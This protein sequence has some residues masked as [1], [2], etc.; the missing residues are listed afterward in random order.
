MVTHPNGAITVVNYIDIS[1]TRYLGVPDALELEDG[2][3]VLDEDLGL[4]VGG[5]RVE[6]VRLEDGLAGGAVV[7]QA[8]V[9]PRLAAGQLVALHEQPG[10]KEG[11][12]RFH[13]RPLIGLLTC[14]RGG[15]R[16]QP[17]SRGRSPRARG[18]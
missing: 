10:N 18:S 2:L 12:D 9:G 15:R 11:Q 7:G 4:A 17:S 6:V 8:V 3:R 5:V 14:S 13:R 16:T 1:P